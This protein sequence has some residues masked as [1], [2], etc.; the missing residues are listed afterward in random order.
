MLPG[1]KK[2]VTISKASTRAATFRARKKFIPIG[3]TM[4]Y[5]KWLKITALRALE[6]FILF[7]IK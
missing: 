5:V 2:P 6:V 1:N 7:Q 3:G 4:C